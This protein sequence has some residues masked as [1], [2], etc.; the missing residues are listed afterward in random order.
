M[1]RTLGHVWRII[2]LTEQ[3]IFRAGFS[4]LLGCSQKVCRSRVLTRSE[5]CIFT[6][7]RLR[8]DNF[9]IPFDCLHLR[10]FFLNKSFAALLLWRTKLKA[11]SRRLGSGDFLRLLTFYF[12]V[13]LFW[14]WLYWYLLFLW[15]DHNSL[16]F[17]RKKVDDTA[18]ELLNLWFG[19]FFF[20]VDL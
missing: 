4:V 13:W 5:S 11:E 12:L 17:G 18:C 6:A 16:S 8:H 3:L 10:N 9:G 15:V 19:S 14:I 1:A 7:Q 2:V 20:L